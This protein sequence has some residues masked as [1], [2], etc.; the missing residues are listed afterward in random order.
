[1]GESRPPRSRIA[2]RRLE[3]LARV[4][5]RLDGVRRGELGTGDRIVVATRNSIYSLVQLDDGRFEVA[6]GWYQRSG[7]GSV[8]LGVS[9]CTAGGA[10]LF[11]RLLAAPGLF[12][13]FE[14]GTRTTRIQNVRLQRIA[15]P[16]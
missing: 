12:L 14:D 8:R 5:E 15:L 7:R 16:A 11:T 4:A 1:M 2:L 6:G 13:E 3:D 10:A 9:G